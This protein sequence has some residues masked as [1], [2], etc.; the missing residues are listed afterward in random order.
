MIFNADG[1]VQ[2]VIGDVID[3]TTTYET[4]NG[5]VTLGS[6]LLKDNPASFIYLQYGFSCIAIRRESNT[7][8]V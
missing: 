4:K 1:T 7:L 3:F 5:T 6:Y 8:Y 2:F